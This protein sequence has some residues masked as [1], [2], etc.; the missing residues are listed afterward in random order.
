M[1]RPKE[2]RSWTYPTAGGLGTWLTAVSVLM[3]AIATRVAAQEAQPTFT[4]L[5]TFTGGTDGAYPQFARLTPDTAGNLCGTAFGGGDRQGFSGDGVVFKV[6]PAGNETVLHTFTSAPDGSQPWSGVVRDE[7]GNLYGTTAL[8]GDG[9]G[10]IFE[11][12]TS[13]KETLLHTFEYLDGANSLGDLILDV[14]GNLY[15]TTF[16]GGDGGYGTAFKLGR[17]GNYGDYRVLHAFTLE[18]GA[19]PSRALT[20]DRAGNLYGTADY[21]GNLNCSFDQSSR[22]FGFDPGCGVIFRLDSLGSETPLY[23]FAGEPDAANP[24]APLIRDAAGNFYGT[25]FG[26]GLYNAG[27]VFKLDATGYETVLY[28]FTGRADGANP[29]AGL[30]R[31]AQGNLYGQTNH[32]GDRSCYCGTVFKLDT[33]GRFTVLHTF[34]G[35]DGQWP[36]APL[37]LFQ[38]ALYGLTSNGG[39]LKGGGLGTG[40]VFKITLP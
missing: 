6:D 25:T 18:D 38:N 36:E 9:Y 5:Y 22:D 39:A 26:G 21:G 40:T 7:A 16:N 12:D 20:R 14:E 3:L 23:A 28:N 1:K 34:T 19:N 17:S 15:G 8:G 33:G 30:V 11:L 4:V 2:R 13:G 24:R 35:P 29:W 37:I 32:A 10:V 31:D 27:T